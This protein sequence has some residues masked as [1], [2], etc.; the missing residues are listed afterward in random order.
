MQFLRHAFLAL[1]AVTSIAT[2]APADL[3]PFADG[4]TVCWVGDSIT[5]GGKYHSYVY[6]YYATRFPERK[7]EFVNCG[8]SGDSAAG[9]L[10]RVQYD[11][12]VHKPTVA[13]IMMG[14][15]DVG[16][17]LYGKEN[18]DAANLKRRQDALKRHADSMTKLT[19]A[20]VKA[21]AKPIFILPSIY[22]E[23]STMAKTNLFGVNG[24]LGICA[25]GAT[26]LAEA[27]Q[28]GVVDFWG[29][30]NRLNAQVQKADPKA[31]IV[32]G[33]RVHPGSFGHFL[34]AYTFLEAQNVP[35][36]VS[37][38]G[39][40]ATGGKAVQQGN[41]AITDV[42]QTDTGLRFTCLEKA[43]P[44]P[45]QRGTE[46]ALKLVPFLEKMNQEILHVQGL[47]VG[48][49]ALLIDGQEVGVYEAKA[50]Q[51][52]IN[53][54]VNAKTPQYKQAQDVAKVNDQRHGVEA[55]SIRNIVASERRIRK[56]DADLDDPAVRRKAVDAFL[57]R[58]AKSSNFRYYKGTMDRYLREKEKEAELRARREQ[59]IAQMYQLNKPK[60][61][62]YELVR[63]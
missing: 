29:E 59:A 27:N 60:P 56:G 15:N 47:A 1:I 58:V 11:V 46:S 40:D 34:M 30:M 10:A 44:Y 25:K 45:I 4:D 57:A 49:Y 61:H 38:M 13:T 6:L 42:K 3:K 54:A 55:G 51:V 26:Q 5:H 9:G 53:L 62:T 35:P 48:N 43:L 37:R 24:A 20:L 39:L 23:T 18:P 16:R 19:A 21:G 8:I 31:T 28:A 22:D 7:I 36:I 52:G 2:A 32:G 50:L 33:D 14:M 63:R 41:C 17:G 12:L